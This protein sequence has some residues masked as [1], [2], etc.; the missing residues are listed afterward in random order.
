MGNFDINHISTF[1]PISTKGKVAKIKPIA[2]KVLSF[3]VIAL[4]FA[5]I[6]RTQFLCD[7]CTQRADPLGQLKKL[8]EQEN[9][10]N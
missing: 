10:C 4:S 7:I 9:C 6:F 5:F 3:R 2:R 1:N 8:I